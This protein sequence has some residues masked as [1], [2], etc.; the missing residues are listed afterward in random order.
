MEGVCRLHGCHLQNVKS[1]ISVMHIQDVDQYCVNKPQ[2]CI[3]YYLTTCWVIED[4]VT[5]SYEV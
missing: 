2:K 4:I 1:A 3:D 5:L